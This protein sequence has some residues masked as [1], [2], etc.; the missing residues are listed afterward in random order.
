MVNKKIEVFFEEIFDFDEK[1]IQ[2]KL[3]EYNK[4]MVKKIL[5]FELPYIK[6]T[7]KLEILPDKKIKSYIEI[8]QQSLMEEMFERFDKK[9]G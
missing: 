8:Q 5:D 3:E 7:T 6:I 2:S 1:N 9:E 4:I